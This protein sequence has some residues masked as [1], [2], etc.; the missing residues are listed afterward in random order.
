MQ[1]TVHV[2]PGSR[3]SDVEAG[4]PWRAH[5]HARPVD[6]KANEELLQLISRH[7]GIPRSAV[8]IVGGRTSRSKTVEIDREGLG[9]SEERR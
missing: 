7:F 3:R 5:V 2:I 8:C 9:R 1:I 6:G 4:D